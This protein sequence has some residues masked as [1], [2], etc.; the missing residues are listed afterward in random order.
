MPRVEAPAW[1]EPEGKAGAES[2]SFPETEPPAASTPDQEAAGLFW[3]SL[4]V[5][6]QMFLN[7]DF[8][9]HDPVITREILTLRVK[10]KL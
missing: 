8:M 10:S 5:G 6:K 2:V 1:V 9:H 4:S 3:E 7:I